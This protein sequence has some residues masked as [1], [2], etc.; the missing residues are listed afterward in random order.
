MIEEKDLRAALKLYFIMGSPNCQSRPQQ[1]LEDAING[2]VTL[3][4]FREKGK[5][6]LKGDEKKAL[7]EEL[8]WI[9]KNH[10]IPFIVNDDI[11]LALELDTDGVHIGQEDEPLESVREKIGNKIIGVSAHTVEEARQAVN[12]GADYL[13]VGPIFPTKSKEDA[14]AAQG[15]SVITDMRKNGIRLPIVGIGGIGRGNAK[16]VIEAGA[17]GISVISAIAGAGDA[18]I[19]AAALKKELT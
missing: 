3:F 9:C 17:D 19:A 2:G 8:Q 14:K 1:V 13:G 12:G 16:S 7:G 5:G 15:T 4:Q 6:A 11:D 10:G 18:A